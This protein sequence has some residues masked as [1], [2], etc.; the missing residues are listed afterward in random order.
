[1]KK[2]EVTN[3]DNIYNAIYSAEIRY[4]LRI[5]SSLN[6]ILIH[7]FEYIHMNTKMIHSNIW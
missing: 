1:M 2:S 4:H 5:G 6:G 3:C 7:I